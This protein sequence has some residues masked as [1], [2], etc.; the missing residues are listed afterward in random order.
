[1]SVGLH[2]NIFTTVFQSK[3]SVVVCLWVCAMFALPCALPYSVLAYLS[4]N[5]GK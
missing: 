4:A 1:M 3:L 2:S 5:N